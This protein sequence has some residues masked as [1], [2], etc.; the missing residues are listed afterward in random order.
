[1]DLDALAVRALH[2]AGRASPD[3]RPQ[4]PIVSGN[5]HGDETLLRQ[6]GQGARDDSGSDDC[7]VAACDVAL[8]GALLDG[9]LAVVK[10]LDAH[11]RFLIP[12]SS[13]FQNVRMV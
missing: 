11:G 10:R 1:R 4:L 13:R 7:A 3:G 5:R 6:K 12:G 2:E 8:A 9:D